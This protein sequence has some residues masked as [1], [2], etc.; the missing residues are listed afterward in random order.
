[1][2]HKS[3]IALTALAASSIASAQDY[4]LAIANVGIVNV[5]TG[6]IEPNRTV[7]ID[8]GKI[9]MI[10]P[11]EDAR[12]ETLE[13]ID[14]TGKFLI[15]GLIDMHVHT[16]RD[17]LPLFLRFGV[18]TVRDM[19]THFDELTPDSRGQI[20]MRREIA[21]GTLEGPELV[22]AL[23]ILD[24]NIPRNP[25]WAMHYASIATPE[26]GRALVNQVADAGGDFVKVY[27]DLTPDVFAAIVD[28]TKTRGLTF[29]GHVPGEV[30][31]AAAA[32]AGLRTAEHL[33]GIFMDISSEEERWRAEFAEEAA[34]L[35]ASATYL[36]TN[37]KLTEMAA[38]RDPA[39]ETAL[40]DVLKENDVGIVPTLVVLDDPRWR[41]PS[42]VPD[43]ELVGELSS[44]YQRIVTPQADV[45]GPFASIADGKAAYELREQLVG[46]MH[47]A[48]V[49]VLVGSDASNP[50][51]VPGVSMHTEL[52]LLVRAGMTPGEALRA[53]T[54]ENARYIEAADRIG[55]VTQ[56]KEADLIL[57]DANP[58]EDIAATRAISAVILNG[59]PYAPDVEDGGE[60]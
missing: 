48:G 57:L 17:S 58:L 24:G 43:P 29:A 56:G 16:N 59:S 20:A 49:T 15:P 14:G 10:L 35:T 50:F 60:S 18:T 13:T 54:L 22:L 19:G 32:Q 53:A 3:L 27:T 8:E 45:K 12:P 39:K 36:F 46:R 21:E 52:G 6:E 33:R 1:M 11:A 51:V 9:E 31:Y 44:I 25:S 30:G 41:Y 42:A 28:E 7:V 26:E 40:F 47:D 2:L 34:K 55:S 37:G 4:D 5:E 38:T 23:R